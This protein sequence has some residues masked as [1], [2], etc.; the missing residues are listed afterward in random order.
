MS[1]PSPGTPTSIVAVSWLLAGSMR[2][3]VPSFWLNTQMLPSPPARNLGDACTGISATTVLLWG[4]TRVTLPA[5]ELVTQTLPNATMAACDCGLTGTWAMTLP[6][7]ASI[8]VRV[9]DFVP[10]SLVR[11][12]RLSSPT[13]NDPSVSLVKF[14]GILRTTLLVVGST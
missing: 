8:R 11:T 6:L 7:T 13:P 14:T 2:A 9:P 1:P 12:Q 4:S 10:P 3:R 5:A